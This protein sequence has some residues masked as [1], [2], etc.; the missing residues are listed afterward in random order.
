MGFATHPEKI[1]RKITAKTMKTVSLFSG[2]GGLDIGVRNAGGNVIFSSDIDLDCVETL[3]MN[4]HT[5]GGIVLNED[6][7]K[8]TGKRI[9]KMAGVKKSEITFLVGGP[10]C[11][12]F[13][14][15]NYWTKSG[16]ESLRRRMREKEKAGLTGRKYIGDQ[17][18]SKK[19]KRVDVADNINTS[20]VMEFGRLIHEL[21]PEGFL[22]ENVQSITHPKNKIYLNEFI[23]FVEGIGYK[24]NLMSLSSEEFGVAQK[25]K[26]I[27]VTGLKKEVPK[28]PEP[29]HSLKPSLYLEQAV[30]VKKVIQK[31][32]SKKYFEP[33][34]VIN[35]RWAEYF[36]D[37]PPGSNY[38]ALTSWAGY[39]NPIFEAETRFWNFL[40][41]LDPEKPSWTIPAS[42]GPWI[43]PFHWENRRLRIPELA[44]IQSF[45]DGYNFFGNRRS[46]VR[47]IGNAA[48]PL[49]VERVFETLVKVVG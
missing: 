33:Q 7:Y 37:I 42:P 9:A 22:F 8:L 25:R 13:S 18:L 6:I 15:N 46:Q 16:K 40:L 19:K 39:H 1:I 43:G 41:K 3:K 20:L 32:K 28:T 26:R 27:F 11:Q 45:P 47:Q 2:A 30:P 29:T 17:V 49:M 10:P 5:N 24:T 12:S 35:G 36:P 23:S 38:K 4:E 48:P 44:S 31:Y 21:S 34:E 14:K